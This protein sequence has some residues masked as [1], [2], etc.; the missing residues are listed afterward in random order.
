MIVSIYFLNIKDLGSE[1]CFLCGIFLSMRKRRLSRIPV[2]KVK[3]SVDNLLKRLKTSHLILLALVL[4]I[5]SEV[6]Y[7]INTKVFDGSV[8]KIYAKL[9][10]EREHIVELTEKGFY[11]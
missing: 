1:W 4:I 11:T 5:I 10:I 9:G 6:F 2:P 3:F 7:L 8:G